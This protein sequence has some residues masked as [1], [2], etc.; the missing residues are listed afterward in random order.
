ME[1]GAADYLVKG[2]IDANLLE[3]SIR[4]AMAHKKAE[5]Q[6]R[7]MA[8]YDNLTSLPNRSL[9]QDRLKQAL[10]NARRHDRL[11]AVIFLDLDNFK[12]INDTLG[13]SV[14][15]LLLKEVSERLLGCIRKSDTVGRNIVMEQGATV[16]R[17]GGD[18]FTILLT[19]IS[20]AEVV[21][22]VAERILSALSQ[23][24]VLE[25]HE[26]FVSASIG[27]TVY[28]LDGSDIENLLKNADTAMYHAKYQGKNNFQYYSSSLNLKALERL[29]IENKMHKALERDEFVLYY[30]PQ[31]DIR[32]GKIFGMEALLRWKSMDLGMVSPGEFIPVAEESGLIVPIGEWVLRTACRQNRAWQKAGLPPIRI[33]VNLSRYQ[34]KKRDITLQ[35]YRAL[36]DSGLDPRYL[37]LE[38]TES[39]MMENAKATVALLYEL[40]A[41]GIRLTLDD[42]GIGYSSLSMLKSFPLDVIKI[43]RSFVKDVITHPDNAAIVEAIIAMARSLKLS[44]IAEGVE[45]EQQL[46]FLFE[47]GCYEI[48]GFLFSPPLPEDQAFTILKDDREGKVVWHSTCRDLIG[49]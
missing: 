30:Q 4:Y 42:F 43:D 48:Q 17:L 44:M 40:R 16:A 22:G 33:S 24:F 49:S 8:Y 26:I 5:Q 47:R 7:F 20:R 1:A 45:T 3:R 41:R 27:I 13:H 37:D 25:G 23:P 9:F 12:R 19:E 28:P 36:N 21:S 32:T 2:K 35:V 29:S 14:G 6:I 10:E 38:I 39:V 46:A 31:I 15:D 18:E 34:F 11:V